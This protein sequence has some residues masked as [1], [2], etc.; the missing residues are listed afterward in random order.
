MADIANFKLGDSVYTVEEKVV[1]KI[2]NGLVYCNDGSIL[3]QLYSIEHQAIL[4][5]LIEA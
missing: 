3:P 1:V 4:E 2:D 5:N